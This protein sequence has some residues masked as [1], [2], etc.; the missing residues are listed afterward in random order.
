MSALQNTYGFYENSLKF[1]INNIG[2][3]LFVMLLIAGISIFIIIK[4]ITVSEDKKY[5]KVKMRYEKGPLTFNPNTLSQIDTSWFS[6]ARKEITDRIPTM[7]DARKLRDDVYSHLPDRPTMDD[8]HNL[9]SRIVSH[10][11]SLHGGFS[12]YNDTPQTNTQT[13][14]NETTTTNES[15][16]SDISE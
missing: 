7:D 11:P 5:S 13:H 9:K 16:N 10:L 8:V 3:I 6:N 12:D 1:I 4:N 14:L 2:A 15:I